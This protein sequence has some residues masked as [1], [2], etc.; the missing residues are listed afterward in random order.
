MELKR[1]SPMLDE[2][3]DHEPGFWPNQRQLVKTPAEEDYEQIPNKAARPLL[4]NRGPVPFR[5]NVSKETS[6]K[7][8][9][10]PRFCSDDLQHQLSD[11]FNYAMQEPTELLDAALYR[12]TKVFNIDLQGGE[13]PI[14]L[15]DSIHHI[16][17]LKRC[18]DQ[19]TCEE[20]NSLNRNIEK[21]LERNARSLME[22]KLYV[23]VTALVSALSIRWGVAQFENYRYRYSPR[24]SDV[25]ML[26]LQN[27]NEDVYTVEGL[28]LSVAIKYSPLKENVDDNVLQYAYL[29]RCTMDD[30]VRALVHMNAEADFVTTPSLEGYFAAKYPG[31]TAH[32]NWEPDFRAVPGSYHDLSQPEGFIASC[33]K[34]EHQKINQQ[35]K[36]LF[37]DLDMCYRSFE[38]ALISCLLVVDE[39]DVKSRSLYAI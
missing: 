34:T 35:L 30:V 29:V 7:F 12:I 4:T 16:F 26:S 28:W 1:L 10:N 3:I 22:Y 14:T 25:K 24:V 27:L 6:S 9:I 23:E 11:R 39:P 38:R 37:E 2:T 32:K 5:A 31:V 21:V 19:L 15:L 13:L 17:Q 8:D 20:V 33:F 36:R 18:E